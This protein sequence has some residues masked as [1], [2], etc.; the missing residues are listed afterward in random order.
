M[1][2]MK[3][4]TVTQYFWIPFKFVSLSIQLFL[5]VYNVNSSFAYL[6]SERQ[7]WKKKNKNKNKLRI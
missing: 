4:D 3:K 1:L 6:V 7:P 5:M 2:N